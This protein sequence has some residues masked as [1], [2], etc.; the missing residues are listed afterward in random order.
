MTNIAGTLVEHGFDFSHVVKVTVYL[1]SLDRDFPQLQ[2]GL[3]D[4]LVTVGSTLANIL[5]EIDAVALLDNGD[6]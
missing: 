2:R 3:R 1:Q 4:H 5:V 6:L